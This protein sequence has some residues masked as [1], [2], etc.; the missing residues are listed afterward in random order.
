MKKLPLILILILLLTACEEKAS[1]TDKPENIINPETVNEVTEG[2]KE[3]EEIN[4]EN[5]AEEKEEDLT[6]D[7]PTLSL[8]EINA[9]G[10]DSSGWGFVKKPGDFPEFTAG[11]IEMMGKYSCIYEGNKEEKCLYLTFDEGYENG[12]TASI[13]DTL[14]EKG[15]KAAFFITGPYLDS[16]FDL[17]KRMLDEGHIVGNHTVRHP[18]MPSLGTAEKMQQEITEL[19]MKLYETFGVHT[20]YFRPP[21]GSYS[22]RS[23]AAANAAGYKNVLWSFAYRDWETD[24]QRGAE[25]AVESVVPYLHNGC[26]ML[27]HAVSKDN[28]EA[29]GTIIDE[30]RSQGYIFKSLDEFKF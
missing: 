28:A 13:L 17:I 23:L 3:S 5:G 9:L 29:L 11:Q 24:K 10:N 16:N 15:V 26:V 25:Y 21:E 4:E 12:Y 27:L 22:E 14:K 6:V 1:D 18:N 7:T 8:S 19:D 30:A 20:K 2:N